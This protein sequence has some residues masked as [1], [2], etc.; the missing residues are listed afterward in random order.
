MS[1]LERLETIRINERLK[2]K[3]FEQ[4][5]GKSSGYIKVLQDKNGIPGSDVIIKVSDYFRNYDLNW[6]LTGEGEMLKDPG[7]A[8]SGEVAKD[9][10]GSYV[11]LESVRNEIRGDLKALMEGMTD[12][13]EVINEGMIRMLMGQEKVLNFI[14]DLEKE[15]MKE[16]AGQLR[17][18]LKQH[19]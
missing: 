3:E 13:F 19:Q 4:I 15:K 8:V 12:N 11:S 10:T 18:Y 14:G 6:L 7:A 16:T 5:I 1:I 9:Q 17:K 2:K